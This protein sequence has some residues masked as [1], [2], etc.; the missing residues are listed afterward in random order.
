MFDKKPRGKFHQKTS[1]GCACL[2]TRDQNPN[3]NLS[4]SSQKCEKPKNWRTNLL[5]TT[6]ITKKVTEMN[7]KDFR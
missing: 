7:K 6:D 4:V 5:H 2:Q 1:N 3:K